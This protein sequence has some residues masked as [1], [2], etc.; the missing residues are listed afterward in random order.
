L[1]IGKNID[2]L[3]AGVSERPVN[4]SVQCVGES[5]AEYGGELIRPPTSMLHGGIFQSFS[6]FRNGLSSGVIAGEIAW[7]LDDFT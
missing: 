5:L 3:W 4:N 1:V 6:I 2:R 7:I